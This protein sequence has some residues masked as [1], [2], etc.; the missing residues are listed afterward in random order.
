MLTNRDSCTDKE[1]QEDQPGQV[2]DSVQAQPVHPHPQRLGPRR[3]A[4][5]ELA[6]RYVNC[7]RFHQIL[8]DIPR[9]PEASEHSINVSVTG[10]QI[11]ETPK[12]NV[13]GK[14]VAKS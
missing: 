4:E 14:R 12:K 8:G 6:P 5:A 7:E 9:R 3:E 13:K 11:G 1:E 10:L 2:Q